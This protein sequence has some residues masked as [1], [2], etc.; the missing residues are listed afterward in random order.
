MTRLRT[1]KAKGF[2][3]EAAAGFLLPPIFGGSA[4][5][6][7]LLGKLYLAAVLAALG[8]GIFLRFKRGRVDESGN[9]D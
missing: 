2:L 7:I 6:A 9:R 8:F 4:A 1:E 3:A 5:L